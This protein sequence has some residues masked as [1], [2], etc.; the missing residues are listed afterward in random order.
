[1]L[2]KIVRRPTEVGPMLLF[3]SMLLLMNAMALGQT[4]RADATDSRFDP[5]FRNNIHAPRAEDADIV[6]TL[7]N[8]EDKRLGNSRFLLVHGHFLDDA[9]DTA[10]ITALEHVSGGDSLE[11]FLFSKDTTGWKMRSHDASLN[12][13]YCRVIPVSRQKDIL[14]CQTNFVGPI[15]QYGNGEVDTNLYAIDFTREPADSTVL[16][17]RDTVT[18]GS[19]CLSWANLKSVEF[20]SGFLHLLVEYGRNRL[21]AVGTTPEQFRN[22]AVQSHGSPSGFPHRLY[23]IEFKLGP[24]MFSPVEG[25]KKDAEY[26][27][28]RW[29]QG[30]A[31]SASIG[32]EP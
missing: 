27:T 13:A 4:S 25:S 23:D 26:V 24:V 9:R 31:C 17:I 8:Y 22:L 21:P 10:V 12:A 14:L 15:G 18:T 7:K 32:R 1:M 2:T 11:T 29:D 30:K 28:E 3:S 6:R 5:T 19:R 20:R 16:Q